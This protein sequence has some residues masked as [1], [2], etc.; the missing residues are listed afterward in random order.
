MKL[1][2]TSNGSSTR[3]ADVYLPVTIRGKRTLALLDTGCETSVVGRRLV[4]DANL[5]PT[6]NRLFAA[7]RTVIPLLGQLDVNFTVNGHRISTKVVVSE[8]VH[9]LILGI[10]LL[11]SHKCR[12]EFGRGM[13]EID[14]RMLQLQS[15]CTSQRVFR[16]YSKEETVIAAAQQGHVPVQVSLADLRERSA[17]CIVEP[18]TLGSRTLTAR[19]L[20]SD[21]Q[22][23]SFVPMWNL[24]DEDFCLKRYVNWRC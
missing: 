1:M 12:W 23:K 14:G 17:N 2:A 5:E 13:I 19:T 10:E 18:R 22:L 16:I 8:A 7:N 15:R 3:S 24:S 9:V 20:F 21:K 11:T 6:S 4:P